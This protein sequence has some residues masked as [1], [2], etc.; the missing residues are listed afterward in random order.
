MIDTI[1]NCFDIWTDA[2]GVKSKGRVKNIDNISLEGIARL[3]E[4]ILDLAI[5]GK[6]VSQ[7]DLDESAIALIKRISE[8]KKKTYRRR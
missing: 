2:Q 8:E 5:Q 3:R 1:I 6:L 7:D 4:L